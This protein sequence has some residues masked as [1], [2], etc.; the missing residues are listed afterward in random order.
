[1]TTVRLNDDIDIKLAMLIELEKT[2]KS[3]IIK[4][5][6]SEYYESHYQERTPYEIG[7]E[8]FGKYGADEDLSQ[9][10]KTRLMDKLHAKHSH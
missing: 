4:K 9:T 3:E 2:T 1:M 8:L 10:Y 6:I 7:E 5:A